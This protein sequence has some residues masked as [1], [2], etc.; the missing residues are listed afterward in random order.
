[1]GENKRKDFSFGWQRAQL[2]SAFFNG[3]FLFA[4][5]ISIF[6]QSIERFISLKKVKN[7]KLVLIMSC[8]GFG[9]NIISMIFLHEHDHDVI[10]HLSG[11]ESVQHGIEG[12]EVQIPACFEA[13]MLMPFRWY[14]HTK[15]IGTKK[16]KHT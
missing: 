8:V 15:N 4:L 13:H 6:L 10:G 16:R 9:L 11:E 5:G 1:M 3:V 2:L 12:T 7:P 14:D